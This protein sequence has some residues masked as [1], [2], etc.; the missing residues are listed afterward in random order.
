V[1]WIQADINSNGF[2]EE[3][4]AGITIRYY[5]ALDR[6]TDITEALRPGGYLFVE[7]HLR[8]TDPTSSGPSSDRYRFGDNE[9]LHASLVLTV[10]FYD[11][12]TRRTLRASGGATCGFDSEVQW[13]ASALPRTIGS[14]FGVGPSGP[15]VLGLG[16]RRSA[17]TEDT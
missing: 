2:P 8:S 14:A 7:Q 6:F 10:L 5:R 3:R 15:M 1:S 13:V 4:Y 16:S 9:L 17:I 11:K 12:S